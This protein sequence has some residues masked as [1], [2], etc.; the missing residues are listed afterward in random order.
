M[1]RVMRAHDWSN[2]VL[3]AEHYWPH[4]LKSA[5]SICL[6]SSF[7]IAIYW[8][9]DLA[10]LYN[11]VWSPLRRTSSGWM[12]IPLWQIERFQ[13]SL[14]P[15]LV[16][17][18]TDKLGTATDLTQLTADLASTFRSAMERAGLEYRVMLQPPCPRP[19]MSIRTCGRRS[20]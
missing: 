9:A 19:P 5:L 12:A 18:L 10:L 7:P 11:D 14:D 17:G 16:E 13:Q 20:S 2:T 1:A 8:G 15:I 6:G 3:R 4:S